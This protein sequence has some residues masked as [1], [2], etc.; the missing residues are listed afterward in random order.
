MKFI[1][2]LA[3]A[4]VLAGCAAS[5][6][7][8]TKEGVSSADRQVAS[9]IAELF[10]QRCVRVTFDSITNVNTSGKTAFTE[11]PQVRR[12]YR[13][14][15]GWVKAEV[16]VQGVWDSIY[17]H[18][19]R[20]L[21]MC[22]EREWQKLSDTSSVQFADVQA[23]TQASAISIPPAPA[24][25]EP[26]DQRPV[27]FRWEGEAN[28]L[29]GVVT[30]QDQGRKG[31]IKAQ[32]PSGQGSCTGV[33]EFGDRVGGQWAVSCTNGLSAVGKFQ[34]LG[35]GRGSVGTGTD[36]KGRRVEFTVGGTP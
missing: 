4:S 19:A 17:Y 36:T 16:Q 11:L 20:N 26:S 10:K 13:S 28:L 8:R 24:T 25:P 31:N 18:E 9:R 6:D 7:I 29:S 30:L 1:C 33:Y 14:T 3:F 32:L 27:A 2:S 34:A 23:S 22:G 15:Q 21:L 35:T 12:I 5:A